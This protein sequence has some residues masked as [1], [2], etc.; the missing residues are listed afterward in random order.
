[1]N[2]QVAQA[3]L[4][5]LKGALAAPSDD[6][7]KSWTQ[8][9]DAT[10]GLTFYD[11]EA[12]AKTLYPVLTPLRNEIPRISGKGGIQ[13]NWKAVTKINA[14]KI[15]LGIMEGAR[16]RIISTETKE[17]LAA[18]RGLGLEDN[19][20]FEAQYAGQGFEDIRARST[21]GLL[22]SFM[23][24]EEA[25]I[26]GGNGTKSLGV[27]PTPTLATAAGGALPALTYS[28]IVIGLTLEA[29]LSASLLDG[30][31]VSGNQTTADGKVQFVR[32]GTCGKSNAATLAVAA[33]GVLTATV[34]AV[35]GVVAYAWYVGAAGAEKLE[36]ITTTNSAS[37]SAVTG[38][39]QLASD[40]SATDYSA[41][42]AVFDGLLT[43]AMDANGGGYYKSMATGAAG[44]GTGLTSSG[45]GGIAEIDEAL[46]FF[47][48]NYKLS[49]DEI[50]VGS[51]EQGSIKTKIMDAPS[52]AAQRFVFTM[53][54]DGIIGGSMAVSYLNPFS[55]G[56]AKEIPIK[57]H[58]NMPDGTILFRT[59]QLP[60]Q[61]SNVPNVAQILA[62][63]DYYS[64]E[65]PLRTRSYEMGVYAD[66]VLQCYAP[67][68][69]GA[70]TNIGK[71]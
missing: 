68:S 58:P 62:R 56:S 19:V 45:D 17:Y 53:S 10:T 6:V 2:Q 57:L 1:M 51:Q 9:N 71:S 37:F 65:W 30:V 8:S 23:I 25:L 32:T 40:H 22:R 7:R 69:L 27:T 4:D 50:L 59:K 48:D 3:T 15:G 54:K 5:A 63:Q 18:Y 11:L 46:K 64:I 47:W 38:T 52:T 55:M 42:T 67:F 34:A 31:Q 66:E 35:R 13:A 29:Y 16:G 61:A 43:F 21:E 60:Y 70:I 12:P 24:G 36:K 33:N 14:G 20:T 39:G 44:T 28:V 26:L 49:P 41:N